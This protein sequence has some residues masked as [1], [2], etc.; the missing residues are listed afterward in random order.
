MVTYR[1]RTILRGPITP[2]GQLTIIICCH[3]ASTSHKQNSFPVLEVDRCLLEEAI[4]S[5]INSKAMRRKGQSRV[6]ERIVRQEGTLPL[7]LLKTHRILVSPKASEI[8]METPI[9]PASKLMLDQE[10]STRKI[11]GFTRRF[12]LETKRV[13]ND[14]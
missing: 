10:S 3:H 13:S 6:F 7:A 9:F 1:R 12:R 5:S 14:L 2:K 11:L 4:G 8:F